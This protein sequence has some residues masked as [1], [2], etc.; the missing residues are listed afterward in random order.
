M[1]RTLTQANLPAVT[2]TSAAASGTSGPAGGHNHIFQSNVNDQGIQ[3]FNEMLAG[4]SGTDPGSVY[5]AIKWRGTAT[6]ANT[7]N[8]GTVIQGYACDGAMDHT[9]TF[10]DHAH[11]VPLGGSGEALDITPKRLSVN[12][13]CFL[14]E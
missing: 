5:P 6:I 10:G 2:L 12:C 13:F 3:N 14:G 11:G 4:F 8:N 7:A 9:H 1:E